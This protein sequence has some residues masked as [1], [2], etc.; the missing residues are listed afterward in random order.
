MAGASSRVVS[1]HFQRLSRL[2]DVEREAEKEETRRQLERLPLSTREAIGKTVT[3]LTIDGVDAGVGGYPRLILSRARR[4]EDLVPFHG[5]NQG[6]NVR[7]AFP[8]RTDPAS[9]DGTL[10]RVDEYRAAVAVAGRLP[11]RLPEGR[12]TLDLLGSDATYRRM[13][14]ALATIASPAPP[15]AHLRD[16]FLG[17]REARTGEPCPVDFFDPDLNRW[18]KQ[19]VRRALCAEEASLVHGPPGTGKTTVLVEI[20]RQAVARGERVLASAPS[21]IAVDNILEKLLPDDEDERTSVLRSMRVVRL[22]HPAR[23]IESLRHGTLLAQVADDEQFEQIQ[24]MNAWRER[25]SKKLARTGG[26]SLTGAAREAAR[27]EIRRLWHDARKLESAISRRLVL[28]AQVVVSTHGG[29]SNYLL[30][31]KF[32]WIAM[33]EASQATEPLSWVPLL[34]GGKVVFTG[35]ADQLPPTIYSRDAARDGLALTLFERLK[36]VLPRELQTL[37]RVQYRMHETIM[38]FS[39]K[40]FYDDEL[41]ADDSVRSHRACDLPGVRATPLTE[42]PLVFVD[43]AG[44]GYEETFNELLQSRENR[45]EAELAVRLVKE[46]LGAGVRPRDVALLTPYMAQVKLLKSLV[47]V[48]RLEIGTVDGFQGREKEVTVLSLVRSNDKGIVGFLSDTRRMNVAV[49][50]ARRLSIVVGDSA[51]IASH[52]FYRDFLDYVQERGEYRSAYEWM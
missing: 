17:L 18:Q 15:A 23:T 12:C 34:R 51:T 35:D 1:E 5:M 47:R 46:V 7:V 27:Q 50:R 14:K 48:P 13:K 30:R 49:T 44:T 11:E 10:D 42:A 2:L 29:I 38:G 21:N 40:Q 31:G 24:E 37:L 32:D 6:D 9:V 36:G 20:I 4:G 25:L 39:S 45:G 8:A 26:R 3:R 16:V 22:G 52:P 41:V 19:A 43:T 28:S 33:D